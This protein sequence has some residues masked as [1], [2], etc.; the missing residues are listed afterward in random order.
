MNDNEK[1]V[2]KVILLGDAGVGKTSL[3]RRYTENKFSLKTDTTIGIELVNKNMIVGSNC[4]KLR[5]WDTAGQER[6][7]SIIKSYYRDAPIVIFVYDVTCKKSFENVQIWL[8]DYKREIKHSIPQYLY[9]IGTK[10]DKTIDND[11]IKQFIVSPEEASEYAKRNN[12]IK[13]IQISN[14]HPDYL[15]D[16]DNIFN[17]IAHRIVKY[18][19]NS[20]EKEICGVYPPKEKEIVFDEKDKKENKN[21][22]C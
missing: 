12:I 4:V 21:C 22:I 11:A 17:D 15:Q 20:T 3:L 14:K 13:S 10:L 7:K 2:I 1:W 16:I 19:E 8:N 6:F 5:I 18:I 9:L